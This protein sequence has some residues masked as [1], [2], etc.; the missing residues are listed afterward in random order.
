MTE[1]YVGERLHGLGWRQ[2]SLFSGA[3]ARMIWLTRQD[4]SSEWD[5]HQREL[6]SDDY[7][8]VVTQTCDLTRAPESE[9][10]VEVIRAY[11]TA[12][13]AIIHEAS[14]N[15]IRRFLIRRRQPAS[16]SAEG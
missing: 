8:L 16:G 12:D 3:S 14:F 13:K 1:L 7:L 15:S 2:G 11:W 5:L 4:S 10:Y 6:D 9:P